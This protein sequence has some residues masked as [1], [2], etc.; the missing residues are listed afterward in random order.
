MNSETIL[1]VI[2]YNLKDDEF[3]S[4]QI[5]KL[6]K[7]AKKD[8]RLRLNDLLNSTKENLFEAQKS[9]RSN[10]KHK[11]K[12]ELFKRVIIAL[13]LDISSYQ[14]YLKLTN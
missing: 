1:K 10:K 9:M 7:L 5:Y 14:K 4:N 13:E 8:L 2:Q 12:Y 11:D 3:I 6:S